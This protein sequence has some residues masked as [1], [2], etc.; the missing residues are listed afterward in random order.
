LAFA[1]DPA[2]ASVSTGGTRN[3]DS[4]SL[5]SMT[6]DGY[7]TRDAKFP[8]SGCGGRSRDYQEEENQ[9]AQPRAIGGD[10]CLRKGQVSR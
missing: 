9:W 1:F 6:Y 3:K 10:L 5:A 7:T 4:M 2:R 8:A